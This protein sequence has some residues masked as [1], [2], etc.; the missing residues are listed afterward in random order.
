[1][2]TLEVVS[3]HVVTWNASPERQT[4]ATRSR[5]TSTRKRLNDRIALDL[6]LM[7]ISEQGAPRDFNKQGEVLGIERF[8]LE[9]MDG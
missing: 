3:S 1:M 5:N 8:R 6:G 9:V 4:S 7:R 2:K